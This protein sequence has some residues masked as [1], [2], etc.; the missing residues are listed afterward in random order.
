MFPWYK[1][2][3]VMRFISQKPN[4]LPNNLIR[5]D[6]DEDTDDED[7]DV[8]SRYLRVELCKALKQSIKTQS[9]IQK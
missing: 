2:T 8:C 6:N 5:G 1:E 7:L 4:E 3:D 9:I